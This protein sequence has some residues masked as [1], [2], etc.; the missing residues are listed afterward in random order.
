M[1][2]PLKFTFDTAFGTRSENENL[3]DIVP[4]ITQDDVDAARTQGFVQGRE[5]G[6]TEATAQFNQDL[7]TSYDKF[8]QSLLSLMNSQTQ[9]AKTN[10]DNAQNYALLIA[11]KIANAALTHY[12]IDQI[13]TLVDDCLSHINLMPH[14]V[15]RVNQ[16]IVQQIEDELQPMIEEKGFEGKLIILGEADIARGDCQI[17][18][19]DGGVAH[20]AQ[21][22]VGTINQTINEFFG[23]D[24]ADIAALPET[25]EI[26]EISQTSDEEVIID[27][28]IT[29]DED[30]TIEQ[31]DAENSQMVDEVLAEAQNPE[32][33]EIPDEDPLAE[34]VTMDANQDE[35]ATEPTGLEGLNDE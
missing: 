18:W 1:A 11:Q 26:S 8:S 3:E 21:Q 6:L 25:P 19:A 16:D 12:P 29:I 22:I 23:F 4:V 24:T 20:D 15:I 31:L 10:E 17:E 32:T 33:P 28:E 27:E 30:V 14:L 5:D 2:E 13:K 7:K 35:F 9:N 34:Q